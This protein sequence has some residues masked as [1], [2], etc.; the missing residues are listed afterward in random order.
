MIP[1]PNHSPSFGLILGF[2]LLNFVLT[3]LAAPTLEPSDLDWDDHTFRLTERSFEID[4][5][6][7]KDK[8]RADQ[9][10][11]EIHYATSMVA[12]AVSHI[13][14]KKNEDY[15]TTFLPET[16]RKKGASFEQRVRNIYQRLSIIARPDQ[17]TYKIKVTCDNNSA[18]CKRGYMAHMNDKE[19]TMN[20]CDEFFGGKL[21]PTYNAIK[22]CQKKDKNFASLRA[23]GRTRSHALAHEWT[24]TSY[25]M[26]GEPRT[27]D[28]AYGVVDSALLADGKF[29]RDA[30]YPT[31]KKPICPDKTNPNVEGLCPAE[32]AMRNADS[33]AFISTAIFYS[34]SCGWHI[35]IYPPG[36]DTS[37]GEPA[38]IDGPV[39][40]PQLDSADGY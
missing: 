24:H 3:S 17:T 10:R 16:E 1:F 18:F 37:S 26:N 31:T 38:Q 29:K 32:W 27:I 19:K 14:D 34:Q 39:N 9:I 8:T 13:T 25:G 2:V 11:K 23:F 30:R 40:D 22:A 12:N 20:V 4:V 33:L 21:S 7:C 36:S 35:P 5:S 15:W 6:S 28:I